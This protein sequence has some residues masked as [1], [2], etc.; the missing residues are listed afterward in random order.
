MEEV[1]GKVK[2]DKNFWGDVYGK[3]G[4]VLFGVKR[5]TAKGQNL[6]AST[7]SV[8]AYVPTYLRRT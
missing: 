5:I 3:W 7:L 8:V 6:H 4:I 1:G 2:R